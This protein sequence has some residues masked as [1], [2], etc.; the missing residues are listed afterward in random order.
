[1]KTDPKYKPDAIYYVGLTGH[2]YEEKAERFV[3]IVTG[4]TSE[5][6]LLLVQGVSQKH[7]GVANSYQW[8]RFY[9][10]D[11]EESW[12]ILVRK[13]SGKVEIYCTNDATNSH[14]TREKYDW[15][16][17]DSGSSKT[18]SLN[19]RRGNFDIGWYYCST[20]SVE[21]SNYTITATTESSSYQLEGGSITY[22]SA[23]PSGYYKY[24]MYDCS[25]DIVNGTDVTISIHYY[26]GSGYFY[27]STK[28]PRP[29]SGEY[30]WFGYHTLVVSGEYLMKNK[31]KA[32]YIAVYGTNERRGF[33]SI[34]AH[35]STKPI[36]LIAGST[37]N[38]IVKD[39]RYVNY[40]FNN[41]HVGRIRVHLTVKNPDGDAMMY[42]AS[43]PS[44]DA[45]ENEYSTS[46][47]GP[48]TITIPNPGYSWYYISVQGTSP[49]NDTQYS[50]RVTA[51]YE[52]LA[53]WDYPFIDDVAKDE[54]KYYETEVS[55]WDSKLIFQTTNIDGWTEMYVLPNDTKPSRTN[56]LFKSTSSHGNVINFNSSSPHWRPGVWSVAIYGKENSDYFIS[57]QTYVGFILPGQPITGSATFKDPTYYRAAVLRGKHFF[58]NIKVFHDECVR[59]Y[60]SQDTA[61]PT[62]ENAKWSGVSNP[63][64]QN[65]VMMVMNGSSLNPNRYYMYVTVQ[66]CDQTEIY[67]SYELTASFEH[68][69]FFL[70]Q[71]SEI[72][73]SQNEY[74]IE[75]KPYYLI[76]ANKFAGG[77]HFAVESCTNKPVGYIVYGTSD[78]R[79][80][81]PVTERNKEFS[82][83]DEKAGYATK[84]NIV[85]GQFKEKQLKITLA[86]SS[87]DTAHLYSIFSSLRAEHPRPQCAIFKSVFNRIVPQ[88]EHGRL[89]PVAEYTFTVGSVKS[90]YYPLTYEFHAVEVVDDQSGNY[91]T[92]CGIKNSKGN[93][94]FR[95]IEV[96]SPKDVELKQF[97]DVSKVYQV[98]VVI[99]DK[100]G[101]TN[102]CVP[103]QFGEITAAIWNTHFSFGGFVFS[104][105]AFGVSIYLIIGMIVKKIVFKS[106]GIN[107]I[108]NL[109][110]WK[111]APALV[112]DGVIFLFTCCRR[113]SI[114]SY[115][116]KTN[117]TI[118]NPFEA[119]E[120]NNEPRG[121][122]SI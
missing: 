16:S 32:I 44:P 83:V 2:S 75:K 97:F 84:V 20:Y 35:S 12:S 54:V 103:V 49:L 62:R 93:V 27:V 30:E 85:G 15:K 17:P 52:R 112:I 37:F 61:Y 41:Y 99:R 48:K 67:R 25:Q 69:P 13:D 65:Q 80:G 101:I 9:Y 102:A 87:S 55:R 95:T 121:Y 50:I 72:I 79:A 8:F 68:Y 40:R 1:L 117:D 53:T 82:S 57:A 42:A 5:K 105:L 109:E 31:P 71:E 81:Y 46:Y 43:Y 111:D 60:A 78:D 92:S 63:L 122:G 119:T 59:V 116:S 3:A 18:V 114:D 38:G 107:L 77:L 113:S 22:A 21:N 74:F 10:G 28:T 56:Y 64:L 19:F 108:P 110:F 118:D 86:K 73:H 36:Q 34:V 33:F 91:Y 26:T 51:D 66:S 100:V 39:G 29:T 90:P 120:V 24:F 115:E 7:R 4:T 47:F 6:T 58:L 98:N 106:E 88:Q 94:I 89:Y 11:D 23:P 45:N 104:C 14:P 96:D 70:S 76:N